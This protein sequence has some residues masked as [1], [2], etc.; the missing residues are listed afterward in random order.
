LPGKTAP[1]EESGANRG[2]LDERQNAER[3]KQW[4][5]NSKNGFTLRGE[6]LDFPALIAI[7]SVAKLVENGSIGRGHAQPNFQTAEA[8][9]ATNGR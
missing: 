7:W 8:E 6:T 4:T 9:R 1:V 3:P 5:H 2:A